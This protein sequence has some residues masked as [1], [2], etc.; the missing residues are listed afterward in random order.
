MAY[1]VEREIGAEPGRVWEI[2]TDPARL[3]DGTFSIIRIDGE[4]AE[5]KTISLWSDV[6]P[7]QRFRLRVARLGEGEM[8]WESGMPFG[9]FTG[10]RRFEVTAEGAGSRFRMTETYR[11]PL[12]GPMV[13]MIPDLQPSFETFG[14]GLK[15]AAEAGERAA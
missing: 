12:A 14:D 4:I 1:Q 13:R 3:A 6:A 2:L 11:G 5:G 9:L 15:R 8:V 7:K 10:S